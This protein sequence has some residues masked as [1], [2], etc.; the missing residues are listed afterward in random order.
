MH[1]RYF[2]EIE[3]GTVWTPVARTITEHDVLAFAAL[4]GDANPVHTDAVF[5]AASPFGEPIAHGLLGL[6]AA[7]GFLSRVGVVD[8]TAIAL[9]GVEWSFRAP[10]RF[11]DTVA[12]EI[13]VGSKR[14]VSDPARG[15][16]VFCFRLT[17]QDDEL[18]QEG[19]H[20]FMVKR[21]PSDRK[22]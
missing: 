3:V 22:D 8:G 6:A 16:V 19:E 4:S 9:L 17:N 7:G 5:A 14:E 21:R 15:L 20:T 18:V 10:I 13:T 12:A 11:G 2:E 1:A